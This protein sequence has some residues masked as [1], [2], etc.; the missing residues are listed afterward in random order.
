ASAPSAVGNLTGRSLASTGRLTGSSLARTSAAGGSSPASSPGCTATGASRCW[1]AS[2]A[3]TATR[4]PEAGASWTRPTRCR[5]AGCGAR[6]PAPSP[7]RPGAR[8]PDGPGGVAGG[9]D[10]R[11]PRLRQEVDAPLAARAPEGP[12]TSGVQGVPYDDRSAD[13]RTGLLVADL[14]QEQGRDPSQGPGSAVPL[15]GAAAEV[16]PG[17]GVARDQRRYQ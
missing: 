7:W 2:R 5:R 8:N 15:P 10:R 3:W 9:L 4:S 1:R 6:G 16:L 12:Q 17:T 13:A 14:P 11:G